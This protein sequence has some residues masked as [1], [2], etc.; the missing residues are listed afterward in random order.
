MVES[1]HPRSLCSSSVTWAW[2]RPRETPVRHASL[3]QEA[4]CGSSLNPHHE[5]DKSTNSRSPFPEGLL[6]ALHRWRTCPR[7]P[8]SNWP[9][10]IETTGVVLPPRE[11]L[12][13]P[14]GASCLSVWRGCPWHLGGVGWR[15]GMLPP[16]YRQAP[17]KDPSSAKRPR[18]KGEKPCPRSS[19]K[20][21]SSSR[22]GRE[23]R[24]VSCPSRWARAGQALVV[25]VPTQPSGQ[26]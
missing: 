1:R 13:K 2:Q 16:S 8:C 5:D 24:A 17:N 22:Q 20:P 12:A 19:A 6:Q 7:S 9:Q 10:W 11:L 26:A 15:P 14:E 23:V 4:P 3:H 25:E 21:A 18:A